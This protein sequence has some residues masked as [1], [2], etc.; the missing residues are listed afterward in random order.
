MRQAGWHVGVGAW[1]SC[2][3]SR[4]DARRLDPD[5]W[6]WPLDLY[7]KVPLG[8]GIPCRARCV[9]SAYLRRRDGVTA[10]GSC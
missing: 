5:N 4:P 10:P 1:A 8:V 9:R 3:R 2:A 7:I 6:S